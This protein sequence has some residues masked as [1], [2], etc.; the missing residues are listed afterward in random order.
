MNRLSELLTAEPGA[1][2]IAALAQIDPLEISRAERIDYLA[3][4]RRCSNWLESLLSR[5]ILSI[6]GPEPH[7]ADDELP[8]E[9]QGVDEAPREEISTALRLSSGSAQREIDIARA[10]HVD[11]PALHR[12][13]ESGDLSRTHARII[14]DESHELRRLGIDRA[15]VAA[16][17]ESA[18]SYS[19]LHTPAQLARHMRSEITKLAPMEA[20]I[21]HAAARGTRRII[22]YP[23]PDGMA[24]IL[25]LLPAE[26]AQRVMNAIN[27]IVRAQ[28]LAASGLTRDG[29]RGAGRDGGRGAGRDGGRDAGRPA[30]DAPPDIQRFM[31]RRDL[32]ETRRADA[33]VLLVEESTQALM[34]ETGA[35][36]GAGA[37]N[38]APRLHRDGALINV[39]IDLPS[40]LGLADTPGELRGYGAIPASVARELAMSG[41]WRRFITDPTNGRLIDIGRSSYTPSAALRELIIARDGSCRFPGCA[42]PPSR[43]DLDHAV[44]WSDGGETDRSNLGLLCRRHH[45]LKT[46]DGWS[47]LSNEDGSCTW[48]APSGHRYH[49]PARTFTGSSGAPPDDL[50]A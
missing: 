45:R 22:C 28:D 15:R 39:T 12:A 9:I 23:E 7:R 41:K 32:L 14:I 37:G 47:L 27:R 29:G 10:L 49:V 3:L 4:L 8:R 25:A 21:V 40:L 43:S 24:T 5:A 42:Q 30:P 31:R 46:H 19:E 18:I 33:F 16:L 38:L 26:A 6:A 34:P 20:E 44:A 48:T 50:A 36:A 17:T 1:E 2:L 13:L 11:M 35:G